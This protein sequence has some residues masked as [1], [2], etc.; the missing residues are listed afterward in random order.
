[1][2]LTSAYDN[3]WV[4]TATNNNAPA[5]TLKNTKGAFIG[6]GKIGYVTSFD[7]IR[8]QKSIIGIEFDVDDS[9]MYRNNIIECFDPTYV[10]FFDNRNHETTTEVVT[11]N[12]VSLH[13]DTGIATSSYYV[14]NTQ[15][16]ASL[17]TV[18]VD[19]YAVR[20]LPYCT[21]QSFTITPAN[22]VVALD[23]YH[24]VSC[25]SAV[26]NPEYNNNIVFNEAS[27]ASKGLYMVAGKGQLAGTGKMLAFSSSY[28]FEDSAK[29]LPV[30]F[31]V[32]ATDRSRCFQKIRLIDLVANTAYKFHIVSAQM[33]EYDFKLPQDETRRILVNVINNLDA[34]TLPLLKLR[35]SHVNGWLSA[36]KHNYT[37]EPK[38]GITTGEAAVL[39]SLKKTIRY[40]LYNIWSS[41]RDGAG[42]EVNPSTF[43]LLDTNGSLFWDGDLFFLPVLTIFRPA[44]ARGILEARY[45]NLDRARR[46]AAGYGYDGSKFP[47][48][49]DIVG[50]GNSPYWDLNGPLHIFNTALVSIGVWNY[51]RVTMDRNW[52]LSKGYTILKENAD[53]F[54]SKV[55]VDNDGTYNIREVYSIND[56]KSDNNALTNYVTKV[57]FK[58]A[59]EASYELTMPTS[60]TWLQCYYNLDVRYFSGLVDVVKQDEAD[61]QQTIFDILEQLIPLTPYYFEVFMRQNSNRDKNTIIRN[62]DFLINK[63]NQNFI[64]HPLNNML[65]TWLQGYIMCCD[66]SYTTT[67]YNSLQNVLSTNVLGIWG[68]F[69]VTNS[70]TDYNDLSL[71]ALFVLMMLTGPG[72]LRVR[73]MVS[74]TRFYTESMGIFVAPSHYLPNTWKN[75]RITGVGKD[76]S[77]YNVLNEVAYP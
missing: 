55:Q 45:K 28:V 49:N 35:Q 57:A 11:L 43:S 47:Y 12:T 73:G 44:V 37:I 59:L 32:F 6:N 53:F 72:T 4:I 63:V 75:I 46:L 76:N 33:S 5:T 24:I 16:E 41:I 74:E 71:S 39:T 30:G 20:H 9:G 10:K 40:N 67:F 42:I 36:W 56:K 48:A 52:L 25:G 38:V 60:S 58:Y 77:A 31:N 8:V 27:S 19:L 69:N 3:E 26:I 66:T 34:P 70:A 22:N 51:Y 23:I 21:V 7:S 17:T 2:S 64:S 29:M 18:A 54:A 1:M 15:D 50:Y 14:S 65:Q 62:L 68:N 13:M 61:T